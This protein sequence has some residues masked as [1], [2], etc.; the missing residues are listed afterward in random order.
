MWVTGKDLS[1][2]PVL[3]HACSPVSL[4]R[5]VWQPHAR[6]SDPQGAAQL[7]RLP[8]QEPQAAAHRPGNSRPS[9]PCQAH[10]APWAPCARQPFSSLLATWCALHLVGGW[11][12]GL[13]LVCGGGGSCVTAPISRR[14]SRSRTNGC[15]FC[16]WRDW[17]WRITR[18]RSQRRW[19]NEANK[20]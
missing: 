19:D 2:W 7:Q 10:P 1:R 15:G 9:P 17:S 13:T 11:E 6:G 16:T 3:F 4:S 14:P 18:P 5:S 20:Q 12:E 8:L